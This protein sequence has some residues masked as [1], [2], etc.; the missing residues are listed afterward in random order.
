MQIE[1]CPKMSRCTN[2]CEYVP[3]RSIPQCPH[4]GT[5]ILQ[6]KVFDQL[7]HVRK[8]DGLDETK[9][10]KNQGYYCSSITAMRASR[11]SCKERSLK[12][13]THIQ[14]GKS[15]NNHSKV[16]N[17]HQDST[18]KRHRAVNKMQAC[19]VQKLKFKINDCLWFSDVMLVASWLHLHLSVLP[20]VVLS[21]F[22]LI[23]LSLQRNFCVKRRDVV[24][25]KQTLGSKVSLDQSSTNLLMHN[26][27]RYFYSN[28]YKK[29]EWLCNAMQ[30]HIC[31]HMYL[32]FPL[33]LCT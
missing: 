18:W 9:N 13:L 8:K 5:I 1:L 25:S 28:I 6:G 14:N 23:S 22:Q 12:C 31:I 3:W 27:C 15:T 24:T 7:S 2:M 33:L 32:Y 4:S 17:Y 16:I 26:T 30:A 20:L 19:F 11:F 21:C 10:I 29:K